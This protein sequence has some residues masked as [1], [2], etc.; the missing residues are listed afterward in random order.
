[1]NVR[2][3]G[4]L[5]VAEGSRPLAIPG[6][7]QRSLLALLL[8]HRNEVVASDRLL[9]ELWVQQP[10]GRSPNALQAAVSRLR[11]ALPAERLVTRPPG[12]LLRLEPAELDAERF[13]HLLADG[14][15]AL[16]EG[17]AEGAGELLRAGLSL[18][19]GPA[20][21]DFTYEPFAQAEIVRLEELRLEAVE[22]RIEAE[23]ALGRQADV[24][25]RL[26]S[27]I[28]EHPLRERPRHQL[29][30]A[31]YRS[32]RQADALEVYRA[33]RAVLKGELGLEPGPELRELERR[34]LVQ[35]P[36]LEPAGRPRPERVR[37][38]TPM[39]R[40]TVTVLACDLASSTGL[41]ET[42]DPEVLHELLARYAAA[43]SKIVSAY[44]GA[45]ES[46][47]GDAVTAVF[48]VP[49]LHEDDALRALRAAVDLRAGVAALGGELG[50]PVQA[51]LGIGTGEVVAGP[52]GPGDG[53]VAG[54]AVTSAG[55]LVR[56][57]SPGEILLGEATRRLVSNAVRVERQGDRE[58]RD[59]PWRLL[60]LV[61]DAPAFARRVETP[62]AGRRAELAQL[63]ESFARA[64][65]EREVRLV[66]VLGPPG[67]GKTRLAR[68]LAAAIS[69]RATV[70]VGRCL[71]YGE[72]ITFWPLRE[73]LPQAPE[74]PLRTRLTAL[75][76]DGDRSR[77]TAVATTSEIFL[78]T[79][80]L[81]E[82]VARERPLLVV[83]EDLHWADPTFLD[84]VE[85]LAARAADTPMLLLCLARDELL[86]LRD[87]W[88]GGIEGVSSIVLEPLTEDEVAALLDALG[89]S[90]H[91]RTRVK[92]VA[93]GNPLFAE[94]MLAWLEEGGGVEDE[95]SLP[96]TIQALLAARL[97]RLGPGEA[98]VLQRAAVIGRDF[99]AET[100]RELVPG[101]AQPFVPRH[102]E[103]LARKGLLEPVTAQRPARA[104]FRFV[105]ALVQ[106]A[107]YRMVP[108]R[109]R[110][111][112]HERFADR[113]GAAASDEI[114][115]HHLEQAHR[116]LEEL[117]P[118]TERS[119]QLSERA[120][121]R[122]AAS[123]RRA[124][125][126]GDMPA[127]AS[128]LERAAALLP[129]DDR[130]RLSI[131]PSL[132]RVLFEQ[133]RLERAEDVLSTAIDSARA[134]GELGVAADASVARTFLRLH[135]DPHSSHE[136]ARFELEGPIRVFEEL[137][138]QGGLARALGLLGI[139]RLWDGR[140]ETAIEELERAV[141]HAR[142]ANDRAQAV[143]SLRYL[144]VAVF[145]GPTP[146]PAALE[147]VE[148]VARTAAGDARLNVTA[149]QV[150]A[151]LLAM[152][153]R[154][155]EA[156][157][158]IGAA[159]TAAQE[160]GLELVVAASVRRSACEIELLAGDP[161]A[162]ERAI[163][164]GYEALER[165]EAWTHLPS[166]VPG[167]A[168][169]LYAQRRFADAL[170]LIEVAAR[171]IVGEDVEAQVGLRRVRAK[172]LARQG[173]IR[174]AERLARE[175]T[176]LAARTD[177]LNMRAQAAADLAEV[178]GL[179]GRP[180]QAAEAREQA[181]RLH[182]LKGNLAAAGRLRA[183]PARPAI[184][185]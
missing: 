47:A 9:E 48:G 30:L 111:E 28:D 39:K 130:R 33:T 168:D 123:G 50:L 142:A 118:P 61:S 44:G 13:E 112:L 96:P 2:V 152:R 64:V 114:V 26:E 16:A 149:L 21:A 156:R 17:D 170:P 38:G 55:Q 154:F 65:R 12:Y 162:A 76:D 4:P 145:W 88:G 87:H 36:A 153:G 5:E 177:S 174:A 22:E 125:A 139:L 11:R 136:G 1:V 135:T 14:R 116:C 23:L 165:M 40:K 141:R 56:Q 146:V 143:E 53:L 155:D 120:A 140:A 73:I 91:V 67:I 164:P 129:S 128:L 94:Q 45:V 122:L 31:L 109:L 127:A 134:A 85:H 84:L 71:S 163:R 158:L 89:A 160:L 35:D 29:M 150:R 19:C 63:R 41:T 121:E 101:D 18:W 79:R 70:L 43:A 60:E 10:S 3:L 182:E 72:G 7:R 15:A 100:V 105:H 34:I 25:A 166:V 119:R 95:P 176:D 126:R 124:F 113:L 181:A 103:T 132:G 92:E 37:A 62:L 69:K 77:S 97:D 183:L 172:L 99:E 144:L 104:G 110:A 86:E 52:A 108:K 180:R 90:P 27:L 75:L 175:A 148:E 178:L 131:L 167:F 107:A 161:L 32:G 157:D 179:A 137:D 159:R 66:T 115:G 102:L 93:E 57:A 169:A 59:E 173:E 138:D 68:E 58:R 147:R 81:L 171:S 6:R 80:L 133:G 20:L 117:G 98:A 74:G 54:A 184:E 78:A 83:L 185:V 8:L 49:A 46:V 42:L 151:H 51:R 106:E 82:S 24:V